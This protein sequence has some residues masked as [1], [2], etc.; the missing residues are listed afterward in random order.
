MFVLVGAPLGILARRGGSGSG[1]GFL[2]RF[3]ALLVALDGGEN[4]AEN[5]ILHP[6]IAMWMGNTVM[7]CIGMAALLRVAGRV[8][9]GHR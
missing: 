7:L 5:N 8:G 1:P 3:R 6:G 2:L 4:L 9:G